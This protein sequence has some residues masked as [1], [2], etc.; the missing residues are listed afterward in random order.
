[1]NERTEIASVHVFRRT[2]RRRE[3]ELQGLID[4]LARDRIRT[5]G[6]Y[7]TVGLRSGDTVKV[8]VWARGARY[9]KAGLLQHAVV[10]TETRGH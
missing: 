1:M 3:R 7:F 2:A 10:F 8:P 4:G 9:Q 6:P 5:D